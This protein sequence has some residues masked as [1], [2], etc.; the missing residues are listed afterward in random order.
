MSSVTQSCLT[1]CDP[2]GCSTPG[3]PPAL[4]PSNT[5]ICII[6]IYKMH[7]RSVSWQCHTLNTTESQ[8]HLQWL[9]QLMLR[10]VYHSFETMLFNLVSFSLLFFLFPNLSFNEIHFYTSAHI[11]TYS[12]KI[13]RWTKELKS[14]QVWIKHYNWEDRVQWRK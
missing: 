4:N 1:L 6:K 7:Q 9:R 3:S 13:Q 5:G 10:A 14:L 2:M 11:F 12:I 8:V